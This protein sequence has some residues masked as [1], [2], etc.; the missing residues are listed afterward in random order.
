[1]AM[2]EARVKRLVGAPLV[3]AALLFLGVGCASQGPEGPCPASPPAAG[4]SC[5]VEVTCSWGTDPRDACRVEGECA[6]AIA[7]SPSLSWAVSTPSCQPLA[8]SCPVAAPTSDGQD[9][10]TSAESGLT[11]VYSGDAFTCAHCSGE[12]AGD[13]LT[14]CFSAL[15][16]GCPADV[17]NYGDACSPESLFCNYNACAPGGAGLV[18]E[19]GVWHPA[20]I[21]CPE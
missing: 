21:A 11:C 18:C 6:T 1:M 14:W 5:S 2:C 4:A 9:S 7:T 16:A 17:P 15:A 3:S 8:A 20:A 19:G 13:A 12:L 10:C